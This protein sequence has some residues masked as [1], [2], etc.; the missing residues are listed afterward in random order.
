MYV[1]VCIFVFLISSFFQGKTRKCQPSEEIRP[2]KCT[3]KKLFK[4]MQNAIYVFRSRTPVST[5]NW[6]YLYHQASIT[7]KFVTN[8]CVYVPDKHIYMHIRIYRHIRTHSL[9][10]LH[11]HTYTYIRT[12]TYIYIHLQIAVER[13]FRGGAV[14]ARWH[15][16]GLQPARSAVTG[17]GTGLQCADRALETSVRNERGASG[18]QDACRGVGCAKSG[19]HNLCQLLNKVEAQMPW[20]ALSVARRLPPTESVFQ[21]RGIGSSV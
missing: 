2:L 19:V 1:Y 20:G 11:I 3:G 21:G 16:D 15:L 7:V 18:A 12:Y 14:D 17:H 13:C 8:F 10:Y 5:A 6:G 4:M 9:L